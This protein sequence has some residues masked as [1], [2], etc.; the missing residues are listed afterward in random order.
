[1]ENARQRTATHSYVIKPSWLIQWTTAEGLSS[2]IT[3]SVI[4]FSTSLKTADAKVKYSTTASYLK[5]LEEAFTIIV[6]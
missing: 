5:P 1:L 3:S 4:L 6:L 2:S